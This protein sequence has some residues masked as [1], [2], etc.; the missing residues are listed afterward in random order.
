MLPMRAGSAFSARSDLDAL[1]RGYLRYMTDFDRRTRGPMSVPPDAHSLAPA[2][3]GKRE[4]ER[5]ISSPRA[6]IGAVAVDRVE[7]GRLSHVR[8]AD[9]G[10]DADRHLPST[11]P[12]PKRT[13]IIIAAEDEGR[14]ATLRAALRRADRP[15]QVETIDDGLGLMARL[16]DLEVETP[17][18]LLLDLD[19]PGMNPDEMLGAIEVDPRLRRIPVIVLSSGEET[20]S[21]Q[22]M[23]AAMD[24]RRTIRWRPQDR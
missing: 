23:L 19:L 17:D 9:I 15:V 5:K 6:I 4:R 8:T 7:V 24:A 20:A 22:A 18:L 10:P 1:L 11:V 14:I 16:L 13:T 21:T 3:P 2:A 12:P